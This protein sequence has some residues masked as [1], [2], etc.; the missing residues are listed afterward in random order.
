MRQGRLGPAQAGDVERQRLRAARPHPPLQVEGEGG[1]GDARTDRRQQAGERA[2]RHGTG[3]PDALDLVR[4]L[5]RTIGLQPALDRHELH[6]RGGSGEALPGGMGDETGLH[7]DSPG[8]DGRDQLRPARREV[9]IDLGDPGVRRL[10]PRLDGVPGVGQDH[11]LVAAHEELAGGAGDLL[12]AVGQREP[13]QVAHVLAADT[14]VGVDPGA[15]EP[16]T[17]ASQPPRPSRAIRVQPAGERRRVR[18]RREIGRFG[19]LAG[20]QV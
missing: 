15:G 14:E 4:L 12:L 13:G 8:A 10:T 11:D 20:H 1:L 7:A 17:Q 16:V 2:V 19:R 5:D 3:R 18:R 6:V 9:A